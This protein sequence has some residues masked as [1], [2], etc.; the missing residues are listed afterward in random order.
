VIEARPEDLP[1][2]IL[3]EDADIIVVN[4]AAGMVTHPSAGHASGSLVNALLFH[5]KDLSSISGSLRPGIVHRLDKDTTGAIVVAKND[6]AHRNLS[7][8]FAERRTKKEYLALCHGV[9]LND[10]F[11]CD[12][13]IGRHP[14]RRTEM[15][16]L[17]RPGEGREA[18]T[19]FEVQE[20]FKDLFFVRALPRT[21]R[22]HQIRVHLAKSGYPILCD[23]L[24][25]KEMALP[26]LGLARHALHA[27]RL[28][29]DHPKS[30]ARVTFEAPLP[31]DMQRALE[32]LRL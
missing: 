14:Q 22:T 16:I 5:C 8:Q 2:A 27:H 12:G 24:Y 18:F 4:K 11:E 6:A 30:G 23:P 3:H 29:F 25:G 31:A 20:R 17:K 21:G 10:A 32:T 13:R 28:G 1:L 9:P 26:T 15:A 19:A 7:E